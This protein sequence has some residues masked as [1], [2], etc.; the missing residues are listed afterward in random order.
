MFTRNIRDIVVIGRKDQKWDTSEFLENGPSPLWDNINN[1][2]K[3][4][5]NPFSFLIERKVLLNAATDKELLELKD[6]S[7]KE[8]TW[9]T[10]EYNSTLISEIQNVLDSRKAERKVETEKK[11]AA[12]VTL[13]T[14]WA[15]DTE[16]KNI[17]KVI[18]HTDKEPLDIQ[19]EANWKL[20][21]NS[22]IDLLSDLDG[23]SGVERTNRWWFRR[24][25][26]GGS[27]Q[28]EVVWEQQLKQLLWG[29]NQAQLNELYARITDLFS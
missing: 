10:H 20:K 1:L 28:K 5:A 9:E 24:A 26:F 13:V 11:A 22:I 21:A 6:I 27:D 17:E 7:M 25:F 12:L 23:T 16:M 18:E 15:V 2:P 19:F 3:D 8:K 14:K 4:P 29:K